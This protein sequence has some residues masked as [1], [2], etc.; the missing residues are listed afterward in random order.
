HVVMTGVRS[1]DIPES[2]RSYFTKANVALIAVLTIDEGQT[3]PFWSATSG[4][5]VQVKIRNLFP[6]EEEPVVQRTMLYEVG[7]GLLIKDADGTVISA[8]ELGKAK[9][10]HADSVKK[11]DKRNRIYDNNTPAEAEPAKS[12]PEK[13][14]GGAAAKTQT[15]GQDKKQPAKAADKQAKPA[16]KEQDKAKPGQPAKKTANANTTAVVTSNKAKGRFIVV[17]GVFNSEARAEAYAKEIK[18]D[19]HKNTAMLSH[20][21]SRYVYL[22]AF[23]LEKDANAEAARI[24]K[25]GT[26]YNGVWVFDTN[27]L[28]KK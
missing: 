21:N 5:P 25:S 20:G 22:A 24:K 11:A 23:D 15:A 4:L 28:K 7:K 1:E 19:G 27:K 10:A 18:A 12:S 8:E 13:A 2:L 6:W 14:E 9:K 26:K 16:A 3:I 17:A